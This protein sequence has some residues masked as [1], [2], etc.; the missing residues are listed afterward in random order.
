[1]LQK[2]FSCP[3]SYLRRREDLNDTS[4]RIIGTTVK[5]TFGREALWITSGNK[6]IK[7]DQETEKDSRFY[8]ATS[9]SV[10]FKS[11]GRCFLTDP[12]SQPCSPP[13]KTVFPPRAWRTPSSLSP[14]PPQC[15]SPSLSPHPH[16]HRTAA[17]AEEGSRRICY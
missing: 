4:F 13:G 7:P 16:P 1:M 15:H 12:D 9:V 2:V 11:L 3:Q 14:H 6:L 5:D 17:T 8:T 10:D